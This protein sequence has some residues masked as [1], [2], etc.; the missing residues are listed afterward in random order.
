MW[1]SGRE[2]V[3]EETARVHEDWR[4]SDDWQDHHAADARSSSMRMS[5]HRLENVELAEAKRQ[6][7]INCPSLVEASYRDNAVLLRCCCS[8]L[9]WTYGVRQRRSKA[10]HGESAGQSLGETAASADCL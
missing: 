8:C 5:G 1:D 10:K 9:S 3:D 2:I 7:Q 4:A 6:D